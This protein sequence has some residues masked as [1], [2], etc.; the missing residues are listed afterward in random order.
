VK[1]TLCYPALV[2]GVK[3]K[4]GM[5]PLGVLYIGALLKREG[6][7]VAVLDGE[8]EG[9]SVR[10]TAQRILDTKPDVVGFSLMTPQLMTALATSALLKQSRP[11]LTIVLGG[12]HVDST[13]GDAFEIADCFD[14][15]IHG[16]GE[17]PMVEVC[18]N[19]RDKGKLGPNGIENLQECIQ[20]VPN[21]VY[22]DRQTREIV[23]NAA[24]AFLMDL[25]QLPS[26]DYDMV[27]MNNYTVPTLKG[28]VISMMLSRG[29]PFKCTYCDAPITMGKKIRFWSMDRIVADIKFYKEKYGVS[30]FSFRDS[31]FTAKKTWVAEFCQ[32]LIDAN[33]N[34]RWRINT[35]ANLVPP[36]LLELMAKAG[37]YTINFGVESGDDEILRR[38]KKEVDLEEVIDAFERCRKL[39]IRTYATFLMGSPGETEDS[40]RRTLQFSKRIRPSLAMFFVAT[41]YPGTPMYDEALASGEVEAR[42]WAKQVQNNLKNTAFQVRW[43]WTDAGALTF[44]NGFAAEEW[45]RRATREWYLRPQFVLDTIEFTVKNPYFLRHIWNLWKEI[46]PFYKLRNLFPKKAI[47]VDERL[48]ILE[49]CPSQPWG[50][51]R[52]TDVK[53]KQISA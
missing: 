42:W 30:D 31:T 23:T 45:Q 8:I 17:Y 13:K 20:E 34:I 27:N 39:G 52:R 22:R 51:D 7:E 9:L 11:N 2:P 26:V 33:L 3:P 21:V 29:C 25:D 12:A 32:R 36:P 14:F 16:E 6:F 35:R 40:A 38:I 5:Q 4:Y 1:V 10:E 48:E 47:S 19:I 50:Q 46:L 43:G 28:R 44:K 24:R 53:E 15:A 41:C 18:R 37:C 49:H